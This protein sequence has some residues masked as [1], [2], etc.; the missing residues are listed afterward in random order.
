[1]T[2]IAW[3]ISMDR[4]ALSQ[5][6]MAIAS[7]IHLLEW[8]LELPAVFG[9][10]VDKRTSSLGIFWATGHERC[11]IN[12]IQLSDAVSLTHHMPD[13]VSHRSVEVNFHT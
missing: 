2:I 9:S 6:P 11:I 1:M 10:E 3:K 7:H 5:I 12:G 8:R 4:K 13:A